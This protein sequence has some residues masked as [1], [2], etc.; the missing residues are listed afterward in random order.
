MS[1]LKSMV[2]LDDETWLK[3]IDLVVSWFND[4]G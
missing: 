4:K 3:A 1:D 2:Y